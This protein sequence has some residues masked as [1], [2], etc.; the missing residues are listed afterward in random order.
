MAQ[1]M[2][3]NRPEARITLGVDTHAEE[4]VVVALDQTGR[5]LGSHRF[6]TTPMGYASLL[7]WASAHGQVEQ[8]GIEG[9]GNYGLGLA[10]WLRRCGVQ[11]LEV[12]QPDRRPRRRQGKSDAADAEAAAR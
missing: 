10:R 4:H 1:D 11:V 6:P 3:T 5:V 9:A 8:V 2:P 7:K 12:A